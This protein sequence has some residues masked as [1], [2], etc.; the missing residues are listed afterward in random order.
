[1]PSLK[2]QHFIGEVDLSPEEIY[3]SVL[4]ADEYRGVLSEDQIKDF[5]LLVM[6]TLEESVEFVRKLI[7]N[8]KSVQS[9]DYDVASVG[10]RSTSQAQ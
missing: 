6:L 1:M 7:S 8:S 9:F 2:R 4:S 3:W 10:L 5:R